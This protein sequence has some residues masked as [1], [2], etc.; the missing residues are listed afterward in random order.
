M[1]FFQTVFQHG[2]RQLSEVHPVS[3]LQDSASQDNIIRTVILT[4]SF[5]L[6]TS[7]FIYLY[8]QLPLFIF[9]VIPNHLRTLMAAP[10]DYSHISHFHTRR[11]SF[12]IPSIRVVHYMLLINVG[13]RTQTSNNTRI[14]YVNTSVGIITDLIRTY[15]RVATHGSSLHH[16]LPC[17]QNIATHIPSSAHLRS[18]VSSR[19]H[20]LPI[21]L[22]VS[23]PPHPIN[24][25]VG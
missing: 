14:C 19:S 10:T 23:S 5:Y 8:Y 4:L 7:A 1:S 18:H 16:T 6:L 9:Q 13:S 25:L 20:M 11:V 17:L 15:H 3:A 2:T 22:F 21:S 24:N 12:P